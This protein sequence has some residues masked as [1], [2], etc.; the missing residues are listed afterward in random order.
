MTEKH[1]KINEVATALGLSAQTIRNYEKSGTFPPSK[2]DAKG[3]RYYTE[4]DINKL[5]AYY[6]PLVETK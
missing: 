3:W 5:K 6:M 2:A 4:D 1:Y